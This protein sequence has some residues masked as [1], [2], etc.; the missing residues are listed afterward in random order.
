MKSEKVLAC[1]A[2]TVDGAIVSG[3][4]SLRRAASS[5]SR[6]SKIHSIPPISDLSDARPLRR[7]EIGVDP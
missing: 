1:G 2:W 7:N 3:R 5:R 6:L 4:S